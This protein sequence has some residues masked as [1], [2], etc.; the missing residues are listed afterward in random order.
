MGLRI[1]NNILKYDCQYGGKYRIHGIVDR[2]GIV[3]SYR[4]LLFNKQSAY[5]IRETNSSA[6]GTYAFNYISYIANGYFI[7]AFDYVNNPLNAAIAD[8]ITPELMP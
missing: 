2:L 4:V 5:C 3:G 6:D 7:I 8:L 1:V